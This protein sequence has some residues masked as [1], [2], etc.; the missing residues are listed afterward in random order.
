VG[1]AVPHESAPRN[2]HSQLADKLKRRRNLQGARER[3]TNAADARQAR[4]AEELGGT[5]TRLAMVESQVEKLRSD[6]LA[7]A[8]EMG[9]KMGRLQGEL[10]TAQVTL[11]CPHP[12]PIS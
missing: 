4:L 12:S 9:S 10:A 6:N 5:R 3:E 7:M 11:A 1:F 2:D 8:G